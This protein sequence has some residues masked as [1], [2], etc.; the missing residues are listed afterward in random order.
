MT[1][2][3]LNVLRKMIAML[4]L[5]LCLSLGITFSAGA[6]ENHC[7]IALTSADRRFIS[8]LPPVKVA[9]NNDL[10]PL[11]GYDADTGACVGFVANLLEHISGK[12]GL[13]FEFVRTDSLQE[14]AKLLERGAV[15]MAAGYAP[16][17]HLMDWARYSNVYLRASLMIVGN[18]NFRYDGKRIVIAISGRLKFMTKD[19]LKIY[20]HAE[21]LFCNDTQELF[22]AVNSGKANVLVRNVYS[23]QSELA[24]S[25]PD[26]A[27]VYDTEK[28]AEYRFAFSKNADARLINIMNR[29]IAAL[30][31]NEKSQMLGASTLSNLNTIDASQLVRILV[32]AIAAACVFLIILLVLVF[33]LRRKNK[34]IQS[35]LALKREYDEILSA[36]VTLDGVF[37]TVYEVDITHD[38]ADSGPHCCRI[39]DLLGLAQDCSYSEM[40]Q[41]LTEQTIKD[42]YK[43]LHRDTFDRE[44]ILKRFQ[45]GDNVRTIDVIR[46]QADSS[47]TWNRLT[48]CAYRSK[49]TGAVKAVI[50]VKDIQAEKETERKLLNEARR[51]SMTGL[52]NKHSAQRLITQI[53]AQSVPDTDFHALLLMDIDNFKKV[54]DTLGHSIGDEILKSVSG[55]IKSCFRERDVVSR[56]GGD[57]FLVFMKDCKTAEA[58]VRRAREILSLLNTAYAN[59]KI[60]VT[61]TLSIGVALYPAHA[62]SYANLFA[63]ADD[64]LYEAKNGGRNSFRVSSGVEKLHTY[65]SVGNRQI[66]DIVGSPA[67]GMI[68]C[69]LNRGLR[70]LYRTDRILS[71]MQLS[72][73]E[74]PPETDTAPYIHPDDRDRLYETL[75][76]AYELR[77]ND[78]FTASFRIKKHDGTYFEVKATVLFTDDTYTDA[79]TNEQYPMFYMIFTNI[80][81]EQAE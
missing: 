20:P 10:L 26:L 42:E 22:D 12:S 57:E 78:S 76:D 7:D 33:L 69:A 51:D 63:L 54:N 28:L 53:I 3:R 55:I 11:E 8:T 32:P 68:K 75:R 17:T 67:D 72:K 80:P 18:K 15:T 59:A 34:E 4:F 9:V 13:K 64:A 46:R 44:N 65:L 27:I 70:V 66:K 60:A 31:E 36:R 41:A 79:A 71:L 74:L 16:E 39:K 14:A 37:D 45:A 50:Y 49:V 23:T 1:P 21:F 30:S 5:L 52:Y 81:E 48:I 6:A 2:D 24:D 77:R 25:Y 47:D 73:A 40:I 56:F 58:A 29:Y 62:D 38:K 61:P 19:L 35:V 43:E